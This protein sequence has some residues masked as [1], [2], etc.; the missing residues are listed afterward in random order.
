[1]P[2]ETA[3]APGLPVSAVAR[4]LGVA[5][6]TLRTWDRRYGLGPTVHEPGAHRRYGPQD[7][8]RLELMQR[9]TLEGVAPADAARHARTAPAEVLQ[10]PAPRSHGGSVLRLPGADAAS[11]GL[12]RAAL[13]LDAEAVLATVVA[14]VERRGTVEAW[15]RVLRP[16]LSAVGARWAATGQGVEVEHLLADCITTALRRRVNVRVLPSPPRPVLLAS[17]PGEQHCLPLYALAAALA[18]RDVAT[19]MLGAAMPVSALA[20][21]IRRTG[22]SVVFLWSQ[23]AP[24]G[25]LKTVSALPVTRPAVGIVVGGPGWATGPYPPGTS[26]A[27]DLADARDLVLEAC[28]YETGDALPEASTGHRPLR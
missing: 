8:Q 27:R 26:H 1:V 22:P 23:L 20:A 25:D 7:I 13:A 9:L 15:E 14:E 6:A 19:R 28:A 18:E 2:D 10:V 3:P 24:T 16:V 11:R 4:R 21:A 17:A 5:P 12:G